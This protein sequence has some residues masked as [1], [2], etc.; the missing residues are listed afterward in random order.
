MGTASDPPPEKPWT[1][2]RG[3]GAILAAGFAALAL[4]PV[5]L[6]FFH[7]RDHRPGGSILHALGRWTALTG[8]A[9]LA[10]QVVS[11]ARLKLLDKPFGLDALMGAHRRLGVLTLLLLAAHPVF[12]AADMGSVFLFTFETP[13]Q[14]SLGKLG[15]FVAI[16]AVLAGVLMTKLRIDYL[17]GR[18][19]HSWVS[20]AVVVLGFVH[21]MTIGSDMDGIA[22]KVYWWAL[23]FAAVGLFLFNELWGRTFGRRRF[24][25]AGVKR[26]TGNVWT[27]TLRPEKGGLFPSRP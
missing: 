10:L 16:L 4:V 22:M 21:S 15:L 6:T 3:A 8:F 1:E 18:F 12:L 13:W 19:V 2:S 14:V 9:L 7:G 26:E 5:G 17:W 25:V 23:L 24:R 11:A 27:L 20:M